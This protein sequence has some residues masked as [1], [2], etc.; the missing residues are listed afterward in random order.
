MRQTN[1]GQQRRGGAKAPARNNLSAVHKR[2][3][4]TTAPKKKPRR[5]HRASKKGYTTTV[6]SY[7]PEGPIRRFWNWRNQRWEELDPASTDRNIETVDLA[8]EDDGRQTPDNAGIPETQDVRQRPKKREGQDQVR[9]G[10]QVK[11]DVVPVS[12]THLTLPT[13][14]LV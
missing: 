13:I 5:K 10:A 14:L 2:N 11:G 8:G 7:T 4:P 12:Y 9:D 1:H 6:T 3:P